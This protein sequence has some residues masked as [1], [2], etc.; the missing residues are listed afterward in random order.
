MPLD[1]V[2]AHAPRII[3]TAASLRVGVNRNENGQRVRMNPL[4]RI[5]VL[6]GSEE[7]VGIHLRRGTDVTSRDE[8][9][10]PPLHLAVARGHVRVCALLLEAGAD[11][12]AADGAGKTA[13]SLALE[14]GPD[15]LVELISSYCPSPERH[16]GAPADSGD[17]SPQEAGSVD[18]PSYSADLWQPYEDAAPPVGQEGLSARATQVQQQISGFRPIDRDPGWTDV[19]GTLPA[20]ISPKNV[21]DRLLRA[22]ESLLVSALDFGW[23]PAEQLENLQLPEPLDSER[24]LNAARLVLGQLDVALTDDAD[25]YPALPPSPP[26]PDD[27]YQL[28]IRPALEYMEGLLGDDSEVLFLYYRDIRPAVAPLLTT[29]DELQ[30]GFAISAA[31]DSAL[32][33]IVNCAATRLAATQTLLAVA[34]G[35]ESPE[36]LAERGV[37]DAERTESAS[38]RAHGEPRPPSASFPNPQAGTVAAL[39]AGLALPRSIELPERLLTAR[40]SLRFIR[41]MSELAD[42]EATPEARGAIRNAT[43]DIERARNSLVEANLRLV[44]WVAKRYL[45]SGVELVD[46]IQEG[47]IGLLRAAEKFDYRLGFRFSTL[48]FWWIRSAV[49]RAAAAYGR[50]IRL[51]AHAA[52]TLLQILSVQRSLE[53]CD[54]E[55]PTTERIAAQLDLPPARVEELLPFTQE[56]ARLSELLEAERDEDDPNTG[57]VDPRSL[58]FEVALVRYAI[59]QTVSRALETAHKKDLRILRLRFGFDGEERTLQEVGDIMHLTRERIRQIQVAAL[60][61]LRRPLLAAGISSLP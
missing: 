27:T 38:D 16:N 35:E 55:P 41:R 8:R 7:A 1:G 61:R 9:G 37:P 40:V 53:S 3:C 48:A 45:S 17:P 59:Q 46:L 50:T 36:T 54:G 24:F 26:V 43:A 6:A 10:N 13:L 18:E 60:K 19:E 33:A 2:A 5:A 56:P 39:S 28:E 32:T 15:K 25:K 52:Q 34:N 49:S 42:R 31:I 30:F 20:Q 47:N 12:L 44:P 57:L 58:E 14:N 11:P 21:P 29:A 22:F 23:L 51:P 4:F